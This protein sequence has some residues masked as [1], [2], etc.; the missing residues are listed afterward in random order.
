MRTSNKNSFSLGDTYLYCCLLGVYVLTNKVWTWDFCIVGRNFFLALSWCILSSFQQT[1]MG[2][3][4]WRQVPFL[5][6][7]FLF[8]G[9][10]VDSFVVRPGRN[11]RYRFWIQADKS[12]GTIFEIC[13]YRSWPIQTVRSDNRLSF[14]PGSLRSFVPL[15]ILNYFL[16][17]H[18][19]FFP[20]YDFVP[21]RFQN[22]RW[23]LNLSCFCQVVKKY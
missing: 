17:D 4:I 15:R 5:S 22:D 21:S 14:L 1:S 11:I 7:W 12:R 3:P 2:K 16:A 23:Y 8:S 19:S 20:D 18:L 9:F 13:C 6:M 10:L